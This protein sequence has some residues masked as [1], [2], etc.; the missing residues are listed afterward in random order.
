MCVVLYCHV[1]YCIY[2]VYYI[3]LTVWHALAACIYDVLNTGCY[4]RWVLGYIHIYIY[5]TYYI[6]YAMYY[7]LYIMYYAFRLYTLYFKL[8]ITYIIHNMLY[9]IC[10]IVHVI[11]FILYTE[12][13]YIV[14]IASSSV[15]LCVCIYIYMYTYI[16]IYIYIYT[17][18]HTYIYICY[19]IHVYVYMRKEDNKNLFDSARGECLGATGGAGR[20][21]E[22]AG[23]RHHAGTPQRG[24]RV[25]SLGVKGFGVKGAT[26]QG[27]S[28]PIR[29]AANRV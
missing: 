29:L 19:I 26:P 25:Y 15:Y 28:S 3:L 12:D 4:I 2:Y 7:R 22:A 21:E 6:L 16:Y 23:C 1:Q 17:Y 11:C 9:A 5:I 18:I 13:F 20:S 24:G 14:N 10:G 27:C 8:L